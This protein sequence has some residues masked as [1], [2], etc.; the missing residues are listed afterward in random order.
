MVPPLRIFDAR[1]RSDDPALAGAQMGEDMTVEVTQY[2]RPDG[3]KVLMHTDI[4]DAFEAPYQVIRRRGWKLASEHLSTGEVSVTVEDD[5]Q[6]FACEI[7]P[8][9]PEVQRAIERCLAEAI[10]T[11]PAGSIECRECGCFTRPQAHCEFC[12][13]RP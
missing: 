1:P 13:E 7:V 10:C 11:V 4:S 6:D 12:G 9:G 5:E 3:R 8:N 2:M